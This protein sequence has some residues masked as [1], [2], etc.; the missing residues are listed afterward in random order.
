MDVLARAQQLRSSSHHPAASSEAKFS[1]PASLETRLRNA[2][3]LL[4]AH[5]RAVHTPD[6]A[7]FVFIVKDHS[8]K[9]EVVKLRASDKKRK[10]RAGGAEDMAV[11]DMAPLAGHPLG[12][13]HALLFALLISRLDAAVPADSRAAKTAVHKLAQ[14]DA[15]AV[16]SQFVRFKPKHDTPRR[17]PEDAHAEVRER[18]KILAQLP[19]GGSI[20]VAPQHSDDG[21]LVRAMQGKGKGRGRGK[22][23]TG[24]DEEKPAVRRRKRGERH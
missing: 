20:R 21:L 14:L 5:E 10:R 16:E 19:P 2:E 4:V 23:A 1:V 18:L 22:G 7:C 3:R 24:S 9:E 17:P 15:E 11:E 8:I 13:Q 12:S 6:L